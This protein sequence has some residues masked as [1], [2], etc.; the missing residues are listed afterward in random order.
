MSNINYPPNSNNQNVNKLNNQHSINTHGYPPNFPMSG[1]VNN[2]NFNRADVPSNG[3][4]FKGQVNPNPFGN[5][6][7]LSTNNQNAWKK[8]QWSN[9]DIN[10]QTNAPS[11]SSNAFNTSFQ[12]PTPII[13]RMDYKNYGNLIHNNIGDEVFD[14]HIVEYR[15][16]IDSIDR[17]TSYYPDPFSYKVMFNPPSGRPDKDGV[18]FSG[19]PQPHILKEFKNVKYV[20]LEQITLPRFKDTS[21]DE[22]DTTSNSSK[23]ANKRYI[24]LRIKELENIFTY[25]TNRKL[26]NNFAMIVPDKFIGTEFYT[27]TPYY[28]SK[29]FKNSQLGNITTL[30]VSFCD[31]KGNKISVGGI[32]T[33]IVDEEDA[34]SPL[35]EGFQHNFSLIIGVVESQV[36]INT[37]HEE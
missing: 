32:D 3:Y 27:G 17:D 1:G 5:Y 34:R 22:V 14:E 33:S 11:N 31:N 24:T 4:P 23:L 12:Q 28:G 13:N 29:I 20:K 15:V 25:G 21:G 26:D 30:T 6:K 19:R 36:N 8:T 2:N 35:Y 7:Y 16:N 10:T 18:Y 37:K 9:F